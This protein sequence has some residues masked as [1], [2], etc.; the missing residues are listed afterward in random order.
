MCSRFEQ[1]PLRA[2]NRTRHALAISDAALAA[3][4]DIGSEAQS[5]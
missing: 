4:L 3:D 2:V 1:I 5:E